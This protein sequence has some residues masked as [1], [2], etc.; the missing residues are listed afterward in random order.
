L[1]L[2]SFGAQLAQANKSEPRY[3]RRRLAGDREESREIA[4]EEE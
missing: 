1:D 2:G 3:I 4:M